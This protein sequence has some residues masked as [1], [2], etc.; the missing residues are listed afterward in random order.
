MDKIPFS[1]NSLEPIFPEALYPCHLSFKSN[2]PGRQSQPINCRTLRDSE[3]L[4]V[5]T[6]QEAARWKQGTDKTMKHEPGS[7]FG[8]N[9]IYGFKGFSDTKTQHNDLWYSETGFCNFENYHSGSYFIL[10]HNNRK[11]KTI[12]T[13][14]IA[15]T[16]D[17]TCQMMQNWHCRK[18]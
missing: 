3:Q 8:N 17:V 5:Q 18:C 14:L 11:V 15:D 13:P 12:N 1:P 4:C 9:Q 6:V 7:P 10:S 16:D 2:V